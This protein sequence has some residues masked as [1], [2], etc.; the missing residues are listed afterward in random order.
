VNVQPAGGNLPIET[1]NPFIGINFVIALEGIF[2]SR[3]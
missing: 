1:R 2:P 3:N